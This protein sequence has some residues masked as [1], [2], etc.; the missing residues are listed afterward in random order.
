[1]S[2]QA[3]NALLK[4]LEEPPPNVLFLLTVPSSTMLLPTVRSRAQLF[5]LD[6]AE[7]CG[8]DPEL[9]SRLAAALCA[10]GEADL[11]FLTAPLIKDREAL[12]QTLEGLALL[13]RDACILRAGASGC[14]SGLPE[15]AARLSRAL[16]RESLVRLLTVTREAISARERNAN[17]ALLVTA[18]CA[19]LR[20]AAGR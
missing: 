14:L 18:L 12:R 16:T 7:P 5:R 8:A 11:L 3:Q 1:M 2:E 20:A 13:L 9:L 17:A 6:G 10:P 15:D 4:V 19:R